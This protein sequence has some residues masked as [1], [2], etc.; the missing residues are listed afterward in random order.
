[1]PLAGIRSAAVLIAALVA[2]PF[3][4][5]TT[6]LPPIGS[7]DVA[8]ADPDIPPPPTEPCVVPLFDDFTFIGFDAQ[9]F[10]YAPPEDCPGPWQ[11][12]VLSI[13]FDVT[14]GRKFDR[15]AEIWLAGANLYFGTTQ[16]PRAAV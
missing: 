5:A 15:T 14:A 7:E 3:A 6:S 13:D 8:I 16:E 12:V 1:M 10:D 11:K 4:V 2:S 9:T